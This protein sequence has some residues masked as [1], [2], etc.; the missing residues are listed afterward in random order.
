L[1]EFYNRIVDT[2]Q[3]TKSISIYFFIT[4]L[5]INI[6][7]KK[8]SLFFN[9]NLPINGNSE[10]GDTIGNGCIFLMSK[11]K[12]FFLFFCFL[13]FMGF[14]FLLFMG[15]VFLLFMGFVLIL[16]VVRLLRKLL[17]LL[18]LRVVLPH[19]LLRHR[20]VQRVIRVPVVLGPVQL[21]WC[22]HQTLVVRLL[23]G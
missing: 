2:V 21:E 6:S 8:L 17:K 19:R 16:L 9:S 3:P 7:L 11:E 23:S 4:H 18:G 12:M 14:V 5:S 13:L 22:H 15:F 1:V 20:I 10:M